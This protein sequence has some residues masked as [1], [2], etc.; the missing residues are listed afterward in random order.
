V[1]DTFGYYDIRGGD[2]GTPRD[3]GFAGL[4]GSPGLVD[5]RP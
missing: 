1:D 5:V 3:T 2:P 4:P